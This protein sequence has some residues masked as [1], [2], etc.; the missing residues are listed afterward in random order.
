MINLFSPI[1]PANSGTANYFRLL[2]R[3][4]LQRRASS[5]MRI[6]VD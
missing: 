6:V 2:L 4:V 3:D 1:P 5:D